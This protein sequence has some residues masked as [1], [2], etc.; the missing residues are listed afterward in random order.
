MSWL[1]DVVRE[2]LVEVAS[3]AVSAVAGWVAARARRAARRVER[4]L[5]EAE[6]P[7]PKLSGSKSS[8]H[9]PTP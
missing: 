7:E 1:I 8:R 3:V 2:P 6:V 9:P 4:R 5:D